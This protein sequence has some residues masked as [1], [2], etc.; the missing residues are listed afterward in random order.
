[1]DRHG[2]KAEFHG[3]TSVRKMPGVQ[4]DIGNIWGSG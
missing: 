4:A 2:E 1:M 3:A